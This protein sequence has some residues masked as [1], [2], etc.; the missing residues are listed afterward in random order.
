MMF[1][2]LAVHQLFAMGFQGGKR[3][4]L[5]CANEPAVTDHISG[6]NGCQTALYGIFNHLFVNPSGPKL[7]SGS[8][9]AHN[10]IAISRRNCASANHAFGYLKAS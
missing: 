7:Q 4:D 6:Q 3:T 5:V 8:A 9:N 2:N 1:G 10:S